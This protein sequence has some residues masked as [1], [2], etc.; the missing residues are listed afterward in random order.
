ME[1]T[2][3]AEPGSDLKDT[4]KLV[5]LVAVWSKKQWEIEIALI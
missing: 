5:C 3:S 1:K 4:R 2:L